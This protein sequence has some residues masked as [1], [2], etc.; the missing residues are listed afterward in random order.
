MTHIHI[1]QIEL[2]KAK[3]LDGFEEREFISSIFNGIK[4]F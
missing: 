2:E 1:N 3:V 4:F